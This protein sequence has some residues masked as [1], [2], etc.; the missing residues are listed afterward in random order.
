LLLL[1]GPNHEV[2][3][4]A[5]SDDEGVRSLCVEWYIESLDGDTAVPGL[6]GDWVGRWPHE[7]L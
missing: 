4:A 2:N 3:T 1:V 7:N 5:A 6:R